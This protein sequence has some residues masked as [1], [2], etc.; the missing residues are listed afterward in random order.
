MSLKA[1]HLIFVTLLTALSFG[2]AAWAFST[3]N[4]FWGAV[5][6]VAGIIVIV[7]GIY[8][9]KKLKRISYL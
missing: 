3:G 7:Y 5:G 2:C 9:L 4:S 1:F 8:F 6:I